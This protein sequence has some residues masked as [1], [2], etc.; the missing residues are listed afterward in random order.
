MPYKLEVDHIFLFSSSGGEEANEL[1]DFGF[2]EGSSRVHV[3]QGT[4]NRK[5]YFDNFFIE[6]LWVT[7]ERE[8]RSVSSSITQLWERSQFRKNGN[9]PFGLC[10]VNSRDTD[11]M[12]RDSK[13]YQPAYFPRDMSIDIITHE[14]APQL[15]WTFR[16]PHTVGVRPHDEPT[17]HAN[18]I[19]RLTHTLF[20]V[21]TDVCYSDF[22]HYINRSASIRLVSS[23]R[24]HLILEFDSHVQGKLKE[25]SNLGLT[26]KY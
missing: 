11:E 19:K 6:I 20:E 15:P 21:N 18:G 13:R 8:I 17:T 2:V 22:T 25:F 12:F 26:I 9:S 4:T 14:Q 23:D 16:L 7:S 24:T 1:T 5:F 10:L 3:G